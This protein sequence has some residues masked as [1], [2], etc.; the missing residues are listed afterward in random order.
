MSKDLTDVD[1]FSS[2]IHVPEGTDL[3][4][5]A[6]GDVELIAQRLANRTHYLN[7][8]T[9]K[10]AGGNALSGT[11]AITGSATI[12]ADLDV[13]GETTTDDLTVV[14]TAVI[15]AISGGVVITGG[16]LDA[17]GDLYSADDVIA[18]DEFQYGTPPTRTTLI[19]LADNSSAIFKS[20]EAHLLFGSSDVA[21]WAIKLPAG[22]T[23]VE[24]RCLI[25]KSG[26][27][28][29]TISL[30]KRTPNFGAP[31]VATPAPF[32]DGTAIASIG[33]WQAL[34]IDADDEVIATGTEYE[35]VF[36]GSADND[37]QL[38]GIRMTWIDPGPRNH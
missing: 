31:A 1:A 20:F 37:D 24:I 32:G 30:A 5:D 12:S 16:G 21:T 27:S 2:P 18:E 29:T 28:T 33:G 17:D 25:F 23:L 6:A 35:L 4:D 13:S 38:H 34:V 10:L 26:T 11:Q 8:R 19:P 3:R 7:Q 22:A 15:P 9:A 14:A 36:Q